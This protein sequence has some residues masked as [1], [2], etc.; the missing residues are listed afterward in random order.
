VLF[1]STIA[2]GT[3]KSFDWSSVGAARKNG[4]MD[5]TPPLMLAGGLNPEN[6][7]DAI[8][9]VNPWGVD[10]SSGVESAPGVKDMDKVKAFLEAVRSFL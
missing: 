1:R 3:G 10:V 8:E 5:T 2:G 9:I 6:V 4:D 7:G